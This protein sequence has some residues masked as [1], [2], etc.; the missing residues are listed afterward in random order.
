MRVDTRNTTPTTSTALNEQREVLLLR[1]AVDQLADA[2]VVEDQL[3]RDETAEEVADLRRDDRDRREQ[4]VA[5]HVPP[6]HR[7]ARQALE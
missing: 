5:Q 4:R 3:D 1:G 2:V 6:D 7:P